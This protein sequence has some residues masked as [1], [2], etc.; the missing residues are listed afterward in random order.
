MRRIT[1]L[2]A[3]GALLT[4]GFAFGH[5][6]AAQDRTPGVRTVTPRAPLA[7]DELGLVETFECVSASVVFI[8]TV[9]EV[10]R[11]DFFNRPVRQRFEG[12]GS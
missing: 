3:A 11:R 5:L 8:D 6:N 10:T 9:S 12:S 2:I 7:G 1:G 4:C